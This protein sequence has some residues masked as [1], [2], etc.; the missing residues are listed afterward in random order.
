M[1]PFYISPSHPL[2]VTQVVSSTMTQVIQPLYAGTYATEVRKSVKQE[3]KKEKIKRLA[4]EKMYASWKTI[5]RKTS[6]INEIKQ[7]CKP[8]HTI[9]HI[10]GRKR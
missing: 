6:T 1:A 2:A 3:T 10:G 8:R 4:K 7:I 5:D 9:G